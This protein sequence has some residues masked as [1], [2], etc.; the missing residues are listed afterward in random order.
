[1]P[2]TQAIAAA[3][4]TSFVRDLETTNAASV[5][6]GSAG[7]V[8][9]VDADNTANNETTYLKLYDLAAGSV[10]FH[11]ST[12]GS[13]TNCAM[14]IKLPSRSRVVVTIDTTDVNFGTAISFAAL[15]TGGT[16]GTTAP[17]NATPVR[18][19]TA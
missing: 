12:A 5:A 10:A 9:L 17:S 11:G 14:Q 7:N 15:T 16:L 18:M 3:A 2:I 4:A 1:M 13:S 6:S 8:L 19:L